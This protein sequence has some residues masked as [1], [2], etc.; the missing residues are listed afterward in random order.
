[1]FQRL[2][3][4]Y[5]A[6]TASNGDLDNY[7]VGGQG[8]W[9]F[10]NFQGTSSAGIHVNQYSALNCSVVFA[11]VNLISNKIAALPWRVHQNDGL[12]SQL[13]SD[14]PVDYLLHIQPNPEMNAVDFRHAMMAHLLT[15]GNAYAEIVRTRRGQVAELWPIEPHLV[16]TKRD[17]EKRLI[18]EISQPGESKKTLRP[19]DIYHVRGFSY[20]GIDG[21]SPIMLARD[22]IGLAQ[23]QEKF[24]SNWFGSGSHPSG[25]LTP[26]I[27]IKEKSARDRMREEWQTAHGGVNRSGRVAIMEHGFKFQP[28]TVPPE[29]SQFLSSREFQIAEICRWYGVQPHK[30][31]ELKRSTNNNIEHQSREFVDDTLLP[32][33][34]K[35]EQEVRS[36]LFTRN[37]VHAG[38]HSN[39]DL[40]GLLRGDLKARTEYY[41]AMLDRGVLSGN[42][43]RRAE[44]ENPYEGGDTRFVQINMQPLE[45][46]QQ[47][48]PDR[49]SGN[50]RRQAQS[51]LVGTDGKAIVPRIFDDEERT[52]GIAGSLGNHRNGT[53]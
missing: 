47:G 33:V 52:N 30:V 46:A 7:F 45:H 1:M 19:E 23:A 39:I 15:W 10:I 51:L 41:T 4:A 20:N 13:R 16:T 8:I 40:K 37:E 6:L 9:P 21:V 27:P 28:I 31:A 35:L 18:Y 34:E 17:N 12:T 2:R 5:H 32:W 26:E 3:A 11:C 50:D 48:P 14:H 29:A 49:R 42:D 53:H 25:I 24:G 22:T 36:K 44:N 43:V 38:Y